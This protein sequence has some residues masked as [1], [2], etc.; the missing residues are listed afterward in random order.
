MSEEL[1]NIE[2]DGVPM[3]ARKNAM[4]IQVTDANGVYVPRF[5]YH[6]KLSIAANCRM[7][8]VEIEKAPKPMPA[9]AT[10]VTEG[11]KVQTHSAAAKTAQNGV[12]EFLLIN[13][14]LDCPICDQ[15]GECQLQDLA[16]GYGGS[17]S[18]YQEEKRVVVNKNLGPL[19]STDMTRCIHCTRCVRFGQ[20]VAGIMELGMAGRGEHS[21]ILSFVGRTVDSELSGN[22]IDLCPVGALTS[23]P[24]RYTAS[25]WELARRR[26]VS[27][28][29]SLGSS[30]MVQAKQER[31]MRVL[32]IEND[33][34]NEC[35]ISDR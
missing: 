21:E 19:I 12:M 20:E 15:G 23:K 1:V 26:S 32:P 11:M 27:P 9:C 8:L 6:N 7:C 34:V 10:P 30:L 2:V 33:D 28:H 22:M 4:I 31:V 35:W 25:T 5:C 3:K 17:A 14:P 16:V 13:H 29:D 24:F 18:R